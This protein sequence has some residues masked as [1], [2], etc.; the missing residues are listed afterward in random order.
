[1]KRQRLADRSRRSNSRSL[2]YLPEEVIAQI[3]SYL[4]E[5]PISVT[6]IRH[7]PTPALFTS[8]EHPLKIISL[9]CKT[10]RRIALPLLFRHIIFNAGHCMKQELTGKNEVFD[11]G[12]PGR[13]DIVSICAPIYKPLRAV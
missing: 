10:I 1:M 8:P 3:V 7:E 12:C 4:D 11:E 13:R 6:H 2:Q 5:P 9:T